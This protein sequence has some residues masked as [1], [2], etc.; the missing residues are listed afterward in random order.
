MNDEK[1]KVRVTKSGQLLDVVVL[2][3]RLDVIQ[4]VLGEGIHNVRCD[5]LPTRNGTAYVGNAMGRE[6]VYERSREDVKAD[7][8][9]AAGFRDFKAT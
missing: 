5:L 1:I 6:I 2:N 8:A 3:K 9:R 7:L 4:I